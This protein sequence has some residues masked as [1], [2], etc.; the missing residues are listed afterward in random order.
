MSASS[1]ISEHHAEQ[2]GSMLF[3]LRSILVHEMEKELAAD[4]SELRMTQAQVVLR[5]GA[6]SP[7]GLFDSYV[8]AVSLVNF[9]ASALAQ[10]QRVP[11]QERL[12]RIERLHVAL[13]DLEPQL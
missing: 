2:L 1:P 8:C 10:Q 6:S 12:E 3:L 7:Q 13:D 5:C 4:P 11:T 9:L